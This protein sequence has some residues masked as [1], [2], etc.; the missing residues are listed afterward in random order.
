[1][2]S[3]KTA[4]S[5]RW[6]LWRPHSQSNVIP[7]SAARTGSSHSWNRLDTSIVQQKNWRSQIKVTQ[8]K[9][10]ERNWATKPWCCFNPT[11]PPPRKVCDCFEFL[12]L[13][14]G[15]MQY[16]WEHKGLKRGWWRGR[17]PHLF[18][19]AYFSYSVPFATTDV[20]QRPICSF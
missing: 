6:K 5:G 16:L 8:W 11:P 10:F 17:C 7:V 3:I 13:A 4:M 2:W 9:Q 18:R 12:T 14:L 19:T 1:M 15:M 20:C